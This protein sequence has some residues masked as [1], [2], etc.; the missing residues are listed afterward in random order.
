MHEMGIVNYII[1]DVKEVAEEN[2]VTQISSVTLEI[3]EVSG[4][5][6]SYLTDYW[7]WAVKKEPLLTGAE[8]VIETLPA[9]T[10][11]EDCK[12]EYETVKYAKT[13]PYCKSEH[14]YL[15]RGNEFNLKSIEVPEE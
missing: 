14:T 2:G 9:V 5:V 7:N 1:K 8:L 3:G 15:L 4:V 10:F 13:C 11:C 12:Q 6:P